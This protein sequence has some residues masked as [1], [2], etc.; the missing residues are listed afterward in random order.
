MKKS[1]FVRK[2]S[3]L[4]LFLFAVQAF[5]QVTRQ[6]YLQVP[7]PTSVIIRWQSGTGDIGKVRYG[8]SLSPLSETIVESEDERIYHQVPVTGLVPNTKYYYTVDGSSKGN[9]E[10]YFIT[11]PSV[12]TGT[13]VRIWAISDFGQTNS[14]N[15]ARRLETVAQ[16]KAFNNG[17]H[18]SFVLSMGDQTED[19]A[20]FQLQHNY[21]DQL[22]PVL[23]S[24]PL[25]TTVGNHDEHDSIYNYKRTFTIPSKAEAGGIASV[26]AEYYSFD[27]ANIHVVSLCTEIHDENGRK[28]QREWLKKDLDNNKQEW[29]I[30]C[31]HQ[32][33]HSGGYHPSD[34]VEY[35]PPQRTDWLPIL[36]DHGV[37]LVLQGHN[38]VYERSYLLDKL[39]GPTTTLTE[40]N[41]KNAG[42]GREDT[43]GPYVKKKGMPHQGT[44]FITTAAG[45]TSNP[46]KTFRHYQI[47]P[48]YFPG[49]D[50]EGSVVIDV[51]GDRMDVKFL[52]DELN[53]K[54]SHVWD[55]FTII[56][57]D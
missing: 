8:T 53:E 56:K 28:A 13:P 15:N 22:E 39:I 20:L 6:P 41:K 36:E 30:A 18:A 44:V 10:Q 7:T 47:F 31:M 54:G 2:Q 42:I 57:K 16:W 12:G 45:G 51:H 52:C 40:A 5:A 34:E 49:S 3:L 33:F 27:Y 21:F 4:L 37:D 50:N 1:M 29:L 24:S 11:A 46:I 26:A 32:P 25:Y 35:A 38:H 14:K 43:G 17:Y 9:E 48:V 55:Y 19:D 23:K